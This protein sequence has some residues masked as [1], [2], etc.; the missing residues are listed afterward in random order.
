MGDVSDHKSPVDQALDLLV[1]AP[2][3]LRARRPHPAA[4]AGRPGPLPGRRGPLDGRARRRQGP[5]GRLPAPDEVQEQALTAL[6]DLG[7]LP[8]GSRPPPAAPPRRGH[9]SRPPDAAPQGRHGPAPTTTAAGADLAIPDYDSL[10]ASQVVPRL[11]GLSP[12]GARGGAGLRGRPTAAARRSSTRSRSS[13][14]DGAPWK[15]PGGPT[16]RRPPRAGASWPRGRGRASRAQGRRA[17]GAGT[18]PGPSPYGPSLDGAAGR[19]PTPLV[20]VGTIDDVVVGYAVGRH[21]GAARRRPP[22]RRH[23]PLRR[24]RAREVGVGEVMMDA[25]WPGARAGC[26]AST[27]RPARRPRR[28]RTSSSASGWPPGPSSSTGRL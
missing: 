23:R 3:G 13:R 9:P 8:N 14:A 11:D 22:G 28:P 5:E 12:D 25:C 21:R 15:G 18:R 19:P 4:Q 20:V 24:A 27:P 2:L 1:Y 26:S 16:A 10:A 6:A 7:L 17:V